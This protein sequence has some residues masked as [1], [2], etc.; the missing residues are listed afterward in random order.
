M[1]LGVVA[2]H[3]LDHRAAAQTDDE[4]ALGIRLHG[5]CDVQVADVFD[6]GLERVGDEHG[7]LLVALELEQAHAVVVGDGEAVEWRVEIRHG[8]D[9]TPLRYG[10]DAPRMARDRQSSQCTSPLAS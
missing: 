2:P 3:P 6:G 4:R 10:A 8:A 7:R 1:H 5:E 9:T